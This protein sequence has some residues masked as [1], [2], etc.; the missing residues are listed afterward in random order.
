MKIG[1]LDSGIGGLT[2]ARKIHEQLPGHEILYW[3]DT[4]RI[5][6]G[7]RHQDAIR[8][9]AAQGADVLVNAGVNLLVLACHTIAAIA[10]PDLAGKLDI[11]LF[12]IMDAAVET[13]VA[14]SRKESFGVIATRAT[15]ESGCY[16]EKIK[17]IRPRA[18]IYSAAA[19]LLVSLVEEGW[20]NRPE[21]NRIVKHFLQPLKMRQIDTLILGCAHLSLLQ[22]TFSRKAGTQI[23]VVDAAEPLALNVR[24]FVESTAVAP[25][26]QGGN[27]RVFVSEKT[28]YLEKTARLFF[29]GNVTLEKGP[30]TA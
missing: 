27:L 6:Y 3:G 20:L 22:K 19:P 25:L 15:V 23:T 9:Y 29:N 2:V 16:E 17:R 18:R 12:S 13:A 24:R 10:A 1:I 4:A 7:D 28:A 11:S 14:A 8:E 30:V 21:T 5:P 26:G